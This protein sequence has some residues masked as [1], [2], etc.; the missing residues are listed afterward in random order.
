MCL[1]VEGTQHRATPG[2]ANVA[3]GETCQIEQPDWLA[4][5][6]SWW[7][8]LLLVPVWG[9]DPG[10]EGIIENAI[11][12]HINVHVEARSA[13]DRKTSSIIHFTDLQSAAPLSVV[14]GGVT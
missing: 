8:A 7:D 1:R 2:I 6:P 12:G 9:P 3:G 11:T 10:P 13:V 14:G 4:V 5:M